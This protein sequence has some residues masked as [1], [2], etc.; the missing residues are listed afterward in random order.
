MK[1]ENIELK[2]YATVGA[3]PARLDPYSIFTKKKDPYS[4]P[5]KKFKKVGPS[6]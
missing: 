5:L 2:M 4:I 6:D 1:K 3:S